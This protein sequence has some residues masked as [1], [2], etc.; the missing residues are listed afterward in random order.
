MSSMMMNA[1]AIDEWAMSP[2][3]LN[4]AAAEWRAAAKKHEEELK[5]WVDKLGEELMDMGEGRGVKRGRGE[6][7]EGERKKQRTT[8]N[9]TP[10]EIGWGLGEAVL[11]RKAAD[12]GAAGAAGKIVAWGV[13]KEVETLVAFVRAAGALPA[14]GAGWVELD[15][16]ACVVSGLEVGRLV[17]AVAEELKG[18]KAAVHVRLEST[19]DGMSGKRV[20]R[21]LREAWGRGGQGAR[22]PVLVTA[23]VDKGAATFE[24]CRCRECGVAVRADLSEAWLAQKPA[25]WAGRVACRRCRREARKSS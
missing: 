20:E 12:I 17:R 4:A 25:A 23:R 18:A 13:S 24:F 2:E 8:V 15:V 19:T 22:H 1:T 11:R 21:A 14:N 16:G 6:R 7:E 10:M 3:E 5:G 9:V